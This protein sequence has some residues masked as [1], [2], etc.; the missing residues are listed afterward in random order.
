KMHAA[1]GNV[2]T[3][4][5]SST[6]TLTAQKAI[7]LQSTAASIVISA[8][9]KIVL[10]GGGGYLKIEGGNIEIGTNGPASFKGAMKELAGGASASASLALKKVGKLA[11]CPSA[12]GA[13]AGRGASAL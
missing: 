1:S 2:N 11:E 6:F 12:T 8:P 3:Q 9:Q 7:D 5:Q 10:N 4:A 13:S